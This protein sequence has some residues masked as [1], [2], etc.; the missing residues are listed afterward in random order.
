MILIPGSFVF[1]L[2]VDQQQHT[3][4]DLAFIDMAL[5]TYDEVGG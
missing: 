4:F 5:N 3:A 2:S 1:M